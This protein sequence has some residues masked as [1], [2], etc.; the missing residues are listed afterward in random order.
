MHLH[1]PKGVKRNIFFS[2]RDQNDIWEG[3]HRRHQLTAPLLYQHALRRAINLCDEP[4]RLADGVSSSS[5]KLSRG[6]QHI[7]AKCEC[8]ACFVERRYIIRV[9]V[10]MSIQAYTTYH[11]SMRFFRIRTRTHT[12]F[13]LKR[14]RRSINGG[15]G[16]QRMTMT[17]G[18]ARVNQI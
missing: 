12:A 17:A 4:A 7:D 8:Q 3:R 9:H 1:S 15:G 16:L 5:S 18:Q 10:H 2:V 14:G 6:A 13:L 11:N